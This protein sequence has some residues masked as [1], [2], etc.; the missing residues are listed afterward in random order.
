MEVIDYKILSRFKTGDLSERALSEHGSHR[1]QNTVTIQNWGP[2]REGISYR[3]YVHRKRVI[4]AHHTIEITCALRPYRA[5][6]E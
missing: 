6:V 1:L 4:A 5:C 3:S 2:V